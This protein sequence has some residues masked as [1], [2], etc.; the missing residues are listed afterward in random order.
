MAKCKKCGKKGLLLKLDANGLCADCAA[1]ASR[2]IHQML[3]EQDAQIAK[4]DE[5]LAHQDKLLQSVLKAKEAY[6]ADGDIQKAIES[7]EGAIV[8][9]EPPLLNAQAHTTF[10]I[11]LYKKSGQNDKAW[12]LLN[13]CIMDSEKYDGKTRLPLYK[14]RSE[15]AKM[16]KSEKRYTDAVE[17]Y[18]LAFYHDALSANADSAEYFEE[19]FRKNIKPCLTKLKWDESVVSD[20]VSIAKSTM[21]KEKNPFNGEVKI[22]EQY[23][24][25]LD[26]NNLA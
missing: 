2:Q 18:L 1:A 20:I 23:K 4:L 8:K 10:L 22:V 3:A 15:M 24:A 26:E 9:A 17:M 16:S 5:D 12:R 14:V 13:D 11:D 19:R 21:A 6:S 25:Y 7:F